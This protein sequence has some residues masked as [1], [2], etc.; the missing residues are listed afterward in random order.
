MAGLCSVVGGLVVYDGVCLFMVGFG[1]LGLG[2]GGL[3]QSLVVYGG[4]L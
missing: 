3:V 1:G 2:F 4:V